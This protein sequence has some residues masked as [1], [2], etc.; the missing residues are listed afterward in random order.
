MRGPR[1]RIVFVVSGILILALVITGCGATEN[2]TFIAQDGRW[3]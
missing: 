1:F 3:S 2:T